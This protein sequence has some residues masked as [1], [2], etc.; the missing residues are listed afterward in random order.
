MLEFLIREKLVPIE[1]ICMRFKGVFNDDEINRLKSQETKVI[2]FLTGEV[3]AQDDR[4][5]AFINSVLSGTPAPMT[6]SVVIWRRFT[7]L[8]RLLD[9]DDV[10]RMNTTL[11][12]RI[13]TQLINS[14]TV[15]SNLKKLHEDE[16]TRLREATLAVWKSL[17]DS[18]QRE[19]ELK[20]KCR[21]L[22]SQLRAPAEIDPL[23]ERQE[24]AYRKLVRQRDEEEAAARRPT[25]YA[26]IEPGTGNDWRE[27]G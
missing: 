19:V 25:T 10:V 20:E 27:Q 24:A 12:E 13:E 23:R 26:G 21:R 22:S 18:K 11:K 3:R 14:E 16:E 15:I 4:Q 6:P 2:P 5:A 9:I 1:E 8:S 7:V 17:D